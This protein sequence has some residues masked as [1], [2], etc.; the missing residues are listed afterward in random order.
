[1]T[2][3]KIYVPHLSRTELNARK[4]RVR[5]NFA[6]AD[7]QFTP[8]E[9]AQCINYACGC[10]SMLARATEKPVFVSL[11]REAKAYY[12]LFGELVTDDGDMQK[13]DTY[14]AT[15]AKNLPY[16]K[17]R[18]H[19]QD[20]AL[21]AWAY[22]CATGNVCTDY[23]GA[24]DT[25]NKQYLE[26]L[27][28]LDNAHFEKAKKACYEALDAGV[29]LLYPQATATVRRKNGDI[30]ER[31]RIYVDR[32]C[33]FSDNV[34]EEGEELDIIDVSADMARIINQL[35]NIGVLTNVLK[36][37][38]RN[39]KLAIKYNADGY[40]AKQT[41]LA[42]RAKALEYTRKTGKKRTSSFRNT[43]AVETALKSARRKARELYPNIEF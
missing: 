22:K 12:S 8:E 23:F 17:V 20:A 25:A 32:V 30:V 3:A 13:W 10:V 9:Y 7:K 40:T 36:K 38:T 19:V 18:D 42:L 35:D 26:A 4:E 28:I 29:K 11:E 6:L 31:T 15:Q 39:E 1:M 41:C 37:L 34:D 14:N 2:N 33:Y 24:I 27:S 16:E 5:A 21:A 43:A